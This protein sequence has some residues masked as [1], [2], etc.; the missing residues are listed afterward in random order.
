MSATRR[1]GKITRRGDV[2]IET[3]VD[4]EGPPFV[5]LPSYGRDSG[6]DFDDLAPA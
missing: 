2:A 1:R 5:V 4:G 3:Y 6:E